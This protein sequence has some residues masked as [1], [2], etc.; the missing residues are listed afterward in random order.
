MLIRNGAD[1]R[2][3]FPQSLP[4]ARRPALGGFPRI[5]QPL[6]SELNVSCSFAWIPGCAETVRQAGPARNSAAFVCGQSHVIYRGLRG[7]ERGGRAF[8]PLSAVGSQGAGGS[9][10]TGCRAKVFPF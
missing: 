2:A 5:E 6:I 9:T 7:G 10:G 3:S 1:S 4:L 8:I